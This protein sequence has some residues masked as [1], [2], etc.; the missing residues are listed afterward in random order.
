MI[1]FK[2][3]ELDEYNVAFKS[4]NSKEGFYEY[5]MDLFSVLTPIHRYNIITGSFFEVVAGMVFGGQRPKHS[6]SEVQPDLINYKGG[7][8][9]EVKSVSWK[10]E[11]K[12]QLEQVDKYGEEF[13]TVRY[14]LFKYYISEP[15]SKFNGLSPKEVFGLLA[16]NIGFMLD[17]PF[18]IINL[19]FNYD[20]FM[21]KYVSHYTA[22]GWD[23]Y[24]RFSSKGMKALLKNPEEVIREFGLKT[25][26][27]RIIKR[28]FPEGA[29]INDIR[30]KPFPIL[31]VKDRIFEHSYKGE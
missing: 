13:F 20:C 12:I 28:M 3:L 24:A 25:G 18:H 16:S 5:Q 21:H 14:T 11:C 23:N 6:N 2:P 31:I 8:E 26:R 4:L 1:R 10:R 22:E 9:R 7:W 30:I 17:L 19:A 15:F 27:Y 29:T